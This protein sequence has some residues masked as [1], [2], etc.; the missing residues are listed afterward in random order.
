MNRRLV[1]LI[2]GVVIVAIAIG[3]VVLFDGIWTYLVGGLLLAFGWPS[4]RTAFL[5]S[6]KEIDELTGVRP[7]SEDTKQKLRDRL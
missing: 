2:T 6:N 7:M 3:V 1:P 4:I 5:A